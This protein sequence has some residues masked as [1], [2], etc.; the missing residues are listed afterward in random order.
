MKAGLSAS[1]SV[2]EYVCAGNQLQAYQSV[3]N[4]VGQPGGDAA[5]DSQVGAC[6]VNGRPSSRSG[7]LWMQS[8]IFFFSLSQV[9]VSGFK[10]GSLCG[11]AASSV[12]P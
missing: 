10:L 12:W 3:I 6:L 9:P 8:L 4:R 11:A 2:W 5:C 7:E 1:A